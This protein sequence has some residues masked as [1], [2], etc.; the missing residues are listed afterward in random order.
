LK[1]NIS[2]YLFPTKSNTFAQNSKNMELKKLTYLLLL[3]VFL[4]VP[5]LLR[6]WKKV[7][8]MSCVRYM[9]PA[10]LCTAFIFGM[11]HMRF[12]GLGI[13]TFNNDYLLGIYYWH[14]PLEEWLSFF[15]I[16]FAFLSVYEGLKKHAISFFKPTVFVVLS[17]LIFIGL[18]ILCYQYRQHLFSFFTF[19]LTCIYL[20]YT[21]FRNRFKKCYARFYVGFFILLIPFVIVSFVQNI[22]PIVTYDAQHIIGQGIWGIPVERFCYLFLMLLINATIY[23][24]LSARRLF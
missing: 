15:I 6:S 9:L 23:E 18:G 21:V 20:G 14:V 17:F 2:R 10:T 7:R 24:Y 5:I 12:V 11:W 16:P 19:F 13:W 3:L 22:L 1:K 8:F 4:L